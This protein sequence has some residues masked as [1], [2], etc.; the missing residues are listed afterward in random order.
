MH[1]SVNSTS[2]LIKNKPS[3]MPSGMG[4]DEEDMMPK[5][6]TRRV[7]DPYA[8]DISDE[9][10]DDEDFVPAPKPPA[11]EESLADFLRNYQPPPEP[12]MPPQKVPKK[13][14]SAPSLM[15]RF[16]SRSSS[17]NNNV[18]AAQQS[19]SPSESRSVLSR[20]APKGHIPLQVNM[21]PGYDKYGPVGDSSPGGGVAAQ[22]SRP[23]IASGPGSAGRVPM[24]KFEPRE[25]VPS[26]SRTSDLA[27]FLRDSEPPPEMDARAHSPVHFEEPGGLAKVFGRRKKTP[28]Y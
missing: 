18:N 12:V 4:F 27:S 16:T 3:P 21:P 22:S 2:A 23:R 8:I 5:R 1:S 11:K 20:A 7:R 25:A 17:S 24:K 6:K 13:K 19:A 28:L 14:A 9:E 15:G 10:M 26:A